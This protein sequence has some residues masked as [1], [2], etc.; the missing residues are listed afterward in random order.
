MRA[1]QTSYQQPHCEPRRHGSIPRPSAPPPPAKTLPA[2]FS[3]AQ[4]RHNFLIKPLE[5]RGWMKPRPYLYFCVRCRNAWRV[6]DPRNAIIPLDRNLEPIDGP[7]RCERIATFAHRTLSRILD[8]RRKNG[9]QTSLHAVWRIVEQGSATDC[10]AGL[11][12]GICG[13]TPRFVK[14][15]QLKVRGC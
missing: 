15:R 1:M 11:G 10:R 8:C 2:A 5:R 12:I 13:K 7:L 4:T 14:L 6:N 3:A 9:S